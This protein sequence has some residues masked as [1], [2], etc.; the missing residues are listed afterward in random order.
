MSHKRCAVS[1]LC[2]SIKILLVF[3]KK[4]FPKEVCVAILILPFVMFEVFMYKK[5]AAF[6]HFLALLDTSHKR[7]GVERVAAMFIFGSTIAAAP[8]G[9]SPR[10]GTL[11]WNIGVVY[12]GNHLGRSAGDKSL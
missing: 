11:K 6:K 1:Y 12:S 7:A 3:F 4:T 2:I 9:P 5:L 10:P 8:L